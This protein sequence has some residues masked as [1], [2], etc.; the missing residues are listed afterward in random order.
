MEIWLAIGYLFLVIVVIGQVCV[1]KFAQTV[2][3]YAQ[4]AQSRIDNLYEY[5]KLHQW[6]I[7]R[8]QSDV[9]KVRGRNR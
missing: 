3:E 9:E 1:F 4:N 8:I 5:V 2:F 7:S 6:Q